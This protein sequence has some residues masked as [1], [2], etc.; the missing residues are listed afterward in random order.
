MSYQCSKCGKEVAAR[1]RRGHARFSGGP[2]GDRQTLPDDWKDWFEP[3][4]ADDDEV[5]EAIEQQEQEDS[6][7]ADEQ[8]DDDRDDQRPTES[9]E[10]DSD[11]LSASERITKAVTE[12][13]RYLWQ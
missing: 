12:D 3:V 13:V 10:S 11:R 6:Q 2:H 8:A 7:Q 4:E 9:P 5:E 1:G